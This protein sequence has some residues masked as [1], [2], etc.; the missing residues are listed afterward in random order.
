MKKAFYYTVLFVLG[1]IAIIG[2]FSTPETTAGMA[3]WA[4]AFI[5]SKAVGL[6]AG[7]AAY[8]LLVRWEKRGR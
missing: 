1:F 2:I 7:Y 3:G 8:R 6:A 5:A 4:V